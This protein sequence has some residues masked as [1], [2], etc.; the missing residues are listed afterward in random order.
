MV[1]AHFRAHPELDF[2]PN[3]LARA[4]DRPTSRGA[5]IKICRRLVEEDLAI[6]TQQRPQRY[7]LARVT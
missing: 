1:L 4:L 2:S 6:R 5:I 3:E 7:R